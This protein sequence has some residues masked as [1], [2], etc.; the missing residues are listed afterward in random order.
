MQLR[1]YP[2]PSPEKMLATVAPETMLVIAAEKMLVILAPEKMLAI[3]AEKREPR[4]FVGK[5]VLEIP[6]QCDSPGGRGKG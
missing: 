1:S 5:N 2:T 3:V 4:G 6:A